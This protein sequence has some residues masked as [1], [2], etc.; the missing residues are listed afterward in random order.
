MNLNPKGFNNS[1]SE[2]KT[3]SPS[4]VAHPFLSY[5]IIQINDHLHIAWLLDWLVAL[6]P[7]KYH[8]SLLVKRECPNRHGSS[9]E[10]AV[11]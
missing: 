4:L 5:N 10:I 1:Q 3:M 7:L 11:L 2:K 9:A 6:P 8:K